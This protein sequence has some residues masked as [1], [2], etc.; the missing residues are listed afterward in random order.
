MFFKPKSQ[1]KI[2]N[3][4]TGWVLEGERMDGWRIKPCRL[5]IED[6]NVYWIN[7]ETSQLMAE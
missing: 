3:Y 6:I 7:V 5:K 4:K 1:D 2:Y